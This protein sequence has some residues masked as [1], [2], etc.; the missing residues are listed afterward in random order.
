MNSLRRD[1]SSLGVLSSLW[2]DNEPPA[3]CFA[4]RRRFLIF[5][6]AFISKACDGMAVIQFKRL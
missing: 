3:M 1:V 2:L 4:L 5:E 6:I